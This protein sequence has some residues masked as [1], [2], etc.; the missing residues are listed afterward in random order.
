MSFRDDLT[1]L[2]GSDAAPQAL[3]DLNRLLTTYGALL[4]PGTQR[5]AWSERDAVLI[6]YADNIRRPGQTPLA[7]LSDVLPRLVGGSV[8]SVHLLPFFPWTSDDGFSVADY[9][10]VDPVSGSWADVE[11]LAGAT[12]L[13]FDAVINHMSASNPW[14]Q[15]FLAGDEQYAG[16]VITESPDTDLSQV[17]RPRTSP[18]LTAFDTAR[19]T[20]YVWTTFSADQVDLNYENPAVLLDITR[21]LLEYVRRGAD[22]IRLDAVTYLWKEVGTSS[23]HHPK[24]HRVIQLLRS[25]LDE[26]AP[27]VTLITETNVPHAENVSYFGDGRN[28]AQLVYNFALPPLVMHSFVAGDATKL[29]SWAAELESPSL[30][31]CFFNFLASHD[32]VGVRGAE[33]ILTHAE[34]RALAAR[35]EAHG[36]LVG[37]RSLA[38][39]SA[40]PYELNVNYFDALS[41]PASDEPVETQVARFLTAQAIMLAIPGVPGIYLHSLV[42]SRGWPEGVAQTGHNRTTNREKLDATTLLAELEKPGHRRQ[43][44]HDG[45]RALLD[46]RRARTAFSP[47]SPA[48]VLA[49]DPRLFVI[50]RGDGDDTVLCVHNVTGDEVPYAVDR[51]TVVAG[52]EPGSFDGVIPP[53]S[54]RWLSR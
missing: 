37:Y 7:T 22:I 29:T 25:V 28:E 53:W 43:R 54:T 21:V 15:G 11:R 17:V 36:G 2:Y 46:A 48:R 38:D 19:G 27:Q 33:A 32:G 10:A 45:Y 42:G 16:Y 30:E 26:V 34:T 4:G 31:T 50:E 20:E 13:M 5:Y 3:A 6:T 47:H 8:N 51:T 24:T 18:L 9:L 40:V 49:S 52:S 35:A 14:F 23:V 44:V 12:R 1:F 41:D 39:G